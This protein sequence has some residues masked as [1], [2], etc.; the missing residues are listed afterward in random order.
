MM[1]FLWFFLLKLGNIAGFSGSYLAS[2]SENLSTPGGINAIERN[3]I[4]SGML[5]LYLILHWQLVLA[6]SHILSLLK[7]SHLWR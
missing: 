4:V 6:S 2:G 5:K 7:N 1:G 3:E